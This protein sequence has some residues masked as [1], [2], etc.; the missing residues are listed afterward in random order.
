MGGGGLNVP[1]V[2]LMYKEII[3]V[4]SLYRA[5][6]KARKGKRSKS[7]VVRVSSN[8]ERVVCDLHKQLQ[9]KT[10][11][12]GAPRTFR[13]YTD[14]QRDVCAPPFVDRIVHHALVDRISPLVERRFIY[15]TYACRVNKGAH[16]AVLAT[17]KMMRRAQAKY[18]KPYIVKTD[19][20]KYFASIPQ[21]GLISLYSKAIA[22][23]DTLWLIETITKGYGFDSGVGI[24]IGALTS[25]LSA[26][27]YLSPLDHYITDDLGIG[28]YV[29]YMDDAVIITEN[30][31]S[32]KEVLHLFER[33]AN[34]IGLQVNPKSKFFPLV[35]GVDFC[36]Y[37]IY[38][39]HI[40]P[41]KRILKRNRRKMRAMMRHYANGRIGFDYAARRVNSFLA[42]MSHCNGYNTTKHILK[43]FILR[44]SYD[45]TL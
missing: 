25:Q 21:D 44:R 37:R 18:G 6:L 2:M 29:R 1:A 20:S 9:D 35:L 33:Y 34:N 24:P 32:A 7:E 22:C 3:S 40:L 11:A 27:Y 12:T 19:I 26:N 39:T 8:I 38:T 43:D 31:E 41:R 36:G 28:S 14:K 23:R 45:H 17:Q 4:E 10:W 30:K 15:H 13:L 16:K 5:Y 42:Y